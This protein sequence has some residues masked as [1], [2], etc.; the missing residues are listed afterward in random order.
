MEDVYLETILAWA[1]G[2][3]SAVED[4]SELQRRLVD[5][6]AGL[7]VTRGNLSEYYGSKWHRLTLSGGR[8]DAAGRRLPSRGCLGKLQQQIDERLRRHD[9]E[10][11]LPLAYFHHLLHLEQMT[12]DPFRGWL[13]ELSRERALWLGDLYGESA[14]P[15][16]EARGRAA[17]MLI[18]VADVLFRA[19]LVE[20]E[21]RSGDVY[22]R[23]LELDRANSAALYWSAFLAERAGDYEGAVRLLRTLAEE[24]PEDLETSLRLAINR[25]RSGGAKEAAGLLEKT[26]R[27]TGADWLRI[28]AYQELGRIHGALTPAP[29]GAGQAVAI[30]RE[31]TRAFPASSRLRLQLSYLLRDDWGEASAVVRRVEADWRGDAG[32]SPRARYGVPRRDEVDDELARLQIAVERRRESLAAILDEMLRAPAG[33][34]PRL[35]ECAGELP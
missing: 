35:R 4:F 1:R 12:A 22:G 34:R 10:A 20:A 11:L 18:A 26:A 23:A 2:S 14:R 19:G 28:V 13:A 16:A 8:S 27:G 6:E 31:A 30:L 17:S 25:L 5:R 15:R 24:H 29:A 21:E 32:E 33:K 3:R 7:E 9:P